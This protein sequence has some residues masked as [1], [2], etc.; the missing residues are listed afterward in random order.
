[1]T[2]RIFGPEEIGGIGDAASKARALAENTGGDIDELI[3]EVTIVAV[4]YTRI[5]LN[6]IFFQLSNPMSGALVHVPG[7]PPMYEYEWHPQLV[8]VLSDS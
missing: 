1:M 2:L 4:N 7:L 8:G 3:E 5:I 6:I